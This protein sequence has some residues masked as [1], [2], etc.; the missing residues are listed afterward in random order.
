MARNRF[1]KKDVDFTHT[2]PRYSISVL[3]MK[4]KWPSSVTSLRVVFKL[5]HSFQGVKRT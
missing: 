1:F 4:V 5:L 3:L 2:S